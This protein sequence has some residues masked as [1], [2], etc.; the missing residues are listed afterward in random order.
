MQILNEQYSFSEY[1][2][3]NYHTLSNTAV[4]KTDKNPSSCNADILV[5]KKDKMHEWI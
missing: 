5:V 3:G 4:V 1:L 2:L